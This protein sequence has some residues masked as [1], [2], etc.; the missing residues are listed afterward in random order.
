MLRPTT[1]IVTAIAA[2]RTR[3]EGY[4]DGRVE[5]LWQLEVRE[6]KKLLATLIMSVVCTAAVAQVGTTMKEGSKATGE[7]AEQYGDQAKGAVSTQ[8]SKT[9]DKAKAQ[10]HKA[11]AHAHA[12][13]AKDAAKDVPK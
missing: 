5:I 4:S 7:K 12:K 1:K 2:Y 3:T 6:M 9:V 8:P 13:A 10:V 11:K